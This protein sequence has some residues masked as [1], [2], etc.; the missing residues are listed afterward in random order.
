M[1]EITEH[2]EV[3]ERT[4]YRDLA[5]LGLRHVPV[6]RDDRGYRLVEGSQLR[7]LALSAAERAV[8]KLALGNP[9]LR[10]SPALARRLDTLEAKLDAAAV[11]VGE[12]PE[13]LTLATVD[14]TG[15]VP[16]A[17][18]ETLERAVEERRCVRL[19]YRSLS[20]RSRRWRRL[21]PYQLFHRGDAWYVVGR[22][23]LHDEP[24]IFR[25]DRIVGA[26]LGDG[27]FRPPAGFSL[28]D[29]L[30]DTW[31]IYRGRGSHEVVLRF[32]P[33]LAPL[34]E[35]ARHHR[36]E[37]VQSVVGG[38]LEYRVRVSHLDEIARWI[39]GFGGRCRVVKP[40][41]LRRKVVELGRGAAAAGR[42]GRSPARG[43]KKT[44]TGKAR[45]KKAKPRRRG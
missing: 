44:K 38:E 6:T 28:D 3:S 13:A 2:F 27:I 29:F 35:A 33:E 8:L 10:T 9:A 25:L 14:R 32:D 1:R 30:A 45:R 37:Q 36:S 7:P 21:D 24:R 39:V 4:I 18:V 5:D 12:T 23:H 40:E 41:A 34:V 42:T 19:D 15:P 16:A 43:G 22:C 26:E 11:A 17:I 31:T 20:G